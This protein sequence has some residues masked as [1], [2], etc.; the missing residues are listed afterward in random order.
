MNRPIG[1]AFERISNLR[2][3]TRGPVRKRTMEHAKSGSERSIESL[4]QK[5]TVGHGSMWWRSLRIGEESAAGD[6]YHCD[7]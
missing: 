1:S 5:H 2:R 7:G 6:Y 4:L 3:P